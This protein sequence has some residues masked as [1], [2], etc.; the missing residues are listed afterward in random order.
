MGAYKFSG[1]A[2][3]AALFFHLRR[4]GQ[5]KRENSGIRVSGLD[6]LRRLRNIFAEH[7]PVLDRVVDAG[8]AQRFLAARP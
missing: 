7:Q 1:I 4:Q 2:P 6:K 8:F 5:G 3:E